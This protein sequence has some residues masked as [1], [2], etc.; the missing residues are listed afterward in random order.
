MEYLTA[1]ETRTATGPVSNR[2]GQIFREKEDSKT[3]KKK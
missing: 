1:G 3:S 2:M